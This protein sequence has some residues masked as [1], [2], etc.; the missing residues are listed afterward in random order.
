MKLFT[1]TNLPL[2]STQNILDS[3]EKTMWDELMKTHHYL[4]FHDLIG[5]GIRYVAV[6]NTEIHA[7]N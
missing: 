3:E 7:L 1:D 4:G 2:L 6:H 5:E